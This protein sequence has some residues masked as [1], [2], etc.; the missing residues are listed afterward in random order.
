[1]PQKFVDIKGHDLDRFP[2]LACHGHSVAAGIRR[3]L[4][5]PCGAKTSALTYSIIETAKENGLNPCVYLQ[6][7]FEELPNRDLTERTI[8]QTLLPWSRE[9]PAYV[10][11]LATPS[12]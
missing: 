1:M 10:K 6:Y 4:N 2:F 5:T 12:K 11:S 3:R 7:L 8:W 9:F